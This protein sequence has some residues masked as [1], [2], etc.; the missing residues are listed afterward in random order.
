MKGVRFVRGERRFGSCLVV[1]QL[2]DN[3]MKIGNGF[4]KKRNLVG[5]SDCISPPRQRHDCNEN[6]IFTS[7]GKPVPAG[8][9]AGV[10]REW[11]FFC[12]A[13]LWLGGPPP[14]YPLDPV[15]V[16]ISNDRHPFERT[17]SALQP[18]LQFFWPGCCW[19]SLELLEMD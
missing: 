8:I 11:P 9:D 3:P 5:G 1:Y 6:A 4:L 10:P 17:L 2:P 14:I 16:G 15:G 12:V 18:V 13:L 7:G 19:E